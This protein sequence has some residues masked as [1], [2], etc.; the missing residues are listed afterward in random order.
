MRL[1]KPPEG[2]QPAVGCDLVRWFFSPAVS[3]HLAA[4][5]FDEALRADDRTVGPVAN[6]AGQ[7]QP[8]RYSPAAG[9]FGFPNLFRGAA[10]FTGG[11]PRQFPAELVSGRCK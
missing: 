2:N 1:T 5:L 6:P 8:E 10:E 3:E 11:D 4:K 7:G 9:L